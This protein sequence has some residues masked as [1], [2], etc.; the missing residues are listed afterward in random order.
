M[1]HWRDYSEDEPEPVTP[2]G[3]AQAY[4]AISDRLLAKAGHDPC[5]W[6][7][8]L[9][10]WA[11]FDLKW[12]LTASERLAEAV[13][14]FSGDSRITFRQKLRNLIDK[15]EAFYDADWSMDAASLPP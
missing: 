1:P 7:A 14:N 3:I 15:H 6:D 8:L 4:A 11:N 2:Q 9:E 10:H 5:R 12:R 13:A